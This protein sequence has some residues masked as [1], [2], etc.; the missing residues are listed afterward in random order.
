MVFFM[1][2]VTL[3]LFYFFRPKDD[4]TILVLTENGRVYLLKVERPNVFGSDIQAA[5]LTMIRLLLFVVA[6]FMAPTLI[7]MVF[8]EKAVG[9]VGEHFN[10][11][12]FL[13]KDMDL[14]ER[15]WKKLQKNTALLA[16]GLAVTLLVGAVW[17]YRNWPADYAT[18]SRQSFSAS[19]ISSIQY[20]ITGSKFARKLVMR[21]FFGK[22]PTQGSLDM[23][24][25]ANGCSAGP[26][27]AADLCT[28]NAASQGSGGSNSKASQKEA[29]AST[30]FS[31]AFVTFLTIIL[32]VVTSAD[33]CFTWFDRVVAL[34]H[35]ATVHEFCASVPND[36]DKGQ[37][38]CSKSVCRGWAD[39]I[40]FDSDFCLGVHWMDDI[41]DTEVRSTCISYGHAE[42]PCCGGCM[43][44]TKDIAG[45][46]WL[47]VLRTCL[48]VIG[49][50]GT[51]LFSLVAA[52]YAL[53]V[54]TSSEFVEISCQR[55]PTCG[56][57]MGIRPIQDFNMIEPLALDFIAKMFAEAWESQ[58]DQKVVADPTSADTEGE[59]DRGVKAFKED[60]ECHS[61]EDFLEKQS[62]VEYDVLNSQMMVN[63]PREPLGL[64]S[65]EEV[66][67]A[68]SEMEKLRLSDLGPLVLNMLG[69]FVGVIIGLQL[70]LPA[71]TLELGGHTLVGGAKVLEGSAA[72]IVYFV[73]HLVWLY[74]VEFRQLM[75]AVVVTDMRI[76]YM[77]QKPRMLFLM[78]GSDLRVDAFRHDRNIYYGRC[79][80]T[81]MPMIMRMLGFKYLPGETFLQ[82][83]FGA[84]KLTRQNGNAMDVFHVI[85]QL[86]RRDSFVTEESLQA[87]GCSDPVLEECKKSVEKG[88]FKVREGV[89]DI[90]LQQTD[91]AA[92]S[93]DIYLCDENEKPLFHWSGTEVGA[94]ESAYNANTDVIVT[95]DRVFLWQRPVYKAFD[96]KT[97]LCWGTCQC[98]CVNKLVEA[99]R[100]PNTVSFLSY[101]ALL[102]FSS[103]SQVDPPLITNPMY[104]P[105]VF[106]CADECCAAMTKLVTLQGFDV[107]TENC[108]PLPR[109]PA[110]RSQLYLM[111]RSKFNAQQPDLTCVVRPYQD[112]TTM[113]SHDPDDEE[114]GVA[115]YGFK[116]METAG[117]VGK[118]DGKPDQEAM[119]PSD[120]KPLTASQ[121]KVK[122]IEVLRRLM[123]AVQSAK[124]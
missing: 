107:N 90:H 82:C 73:I 67:A 81:T 36:P 96:C 62:I 47:E 9:D 93:P 113:E 114:E 37:E 103:E 17:L 53:N 50:I 27:D 110:A 18:R 59:K 99:N 43:L 101:A 55:P 72:A 91:A 8:G 85:S 78:F 104:P 77:R 10:E 1:M 109:R 124:A 121:E 102:S 19:N 69:I 111:W 60:L 40:N 97:C 42:P 48:E 21:L 108:S 16:G 29:A 75:H 32:F 12:S 64:G 39:K 89:W 2:T 20:T 79:K 46:S 112:Q 28:P 61:W 92:R 24:G 80:N 13:E 26:I 115:K 56:G 118:D 106:P 86:S 94:I 70:F 116:L 34:S 74:L 4:D 83:K 41:E 31:P 100:L 33:A 5:F 63:L 119:N 52:K 105:V 120:G 66:I 45:G 23:A 30:N 95:T 123:A 3:G 117:L 57:L 98:G 84:M 35:I 38:M 65:N 22:Y 7:W 6:V 76:F 14:N 25:L 87:A 51:L 58:T 49:D 88:M 54:S 44:S 71:Q 15:M 11:E 122:E 68:W